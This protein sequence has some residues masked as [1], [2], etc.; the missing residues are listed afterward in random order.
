MLESIF[1]K[2]VSLPAFNFIKKRV[3]Q[4]CFSCEYFE[5]FKNSFFDGTPLVAASAQR[6]YL[7]VQLVGRQR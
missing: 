7:N 2:V 4:R 6:E 3:Q 1:I 5:I